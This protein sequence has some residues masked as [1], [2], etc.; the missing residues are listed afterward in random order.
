[1][2]RYDIKMVVPDNGGVV[3]IHS[4]PQ[5][6]S[7]YTCDEFTAQAVGETLLSMIAAISLDPPAAPAPLKTAA[8]APTAISDLIK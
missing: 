1:M 2:K 8:P 7:M 5:A 3:F 4:S 6:N